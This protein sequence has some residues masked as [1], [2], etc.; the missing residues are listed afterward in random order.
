MIACAQF[1]N[2]PKQRDMD[3]LFCGVDIK[4]YITKSLFEKIVRSYKSEPEGDLLP[5]W[6]PNYLGDSDYFLHIQDFDAQWASSMSSKI[7]HKNKNMSV[8]RLFMDFPKDSGE[9]LAICVRL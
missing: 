3:D 5:P 2:K 8:V 6:S 4:K 1:V 9:S 7:I